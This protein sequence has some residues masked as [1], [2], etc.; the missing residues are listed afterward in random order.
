MKCRYGPP[1][2]ADVPHKDGNWYTYREIY[3]RECEL[4]NNKISD[5]FYRIHKCEFYDK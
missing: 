3:I 4:C 1:K 2:R 5:E